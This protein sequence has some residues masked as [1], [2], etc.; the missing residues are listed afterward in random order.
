MQDERSLTPEDREMA[1]TLSSLRPTPPRLTRDAVLLETYRRAGRRQTWLWRGI[2]AALAAGLVLSL[3][4]RPQS[5][6][7]EKVV[8]VPRPMTVAES[9]SPATVESTR[10]S[11]QSAESAPGGYLALRH[12][13]LAWGPAALPHVPAATSGKIP[14]P[15]RLVSPTQS[16]STIFDFLKSG[17]GG[18]S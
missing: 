1:E 16:S 18:R 12:D 17:F 11:F 15:E 13:V 5:R 3:V 14:Q 4:F 10:S 2:A 7:T 9:E 8:Y 6:T